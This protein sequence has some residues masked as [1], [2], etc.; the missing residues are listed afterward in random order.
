MSEA[1]RYELAPLGIDVVLVEPGPFATNFFGAMVNAE[2]QEVAKA[3][4]HVGEFFA[5]FESQVQSLFEDENAP[6]DPKV[7]VEIFD[8]LID[9]PAGTRPLRTIAGLDFGFQSLNDATE[10]I[11]KAALSG[12]G[13]GDWDGPKS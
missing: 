1:M 7:V 5:G 13:I 2:D 10:P 8:K 6:T 11:R 3:Y 12:M 4:Q 9:M